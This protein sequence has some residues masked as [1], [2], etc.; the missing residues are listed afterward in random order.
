M[1]YINKKPFLSW[2]EE[3]GKSNTAASVSLAAM[4]I[5]KLE[6]KREAKGFKEP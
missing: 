5:R 6:K 1:F 3:G 4:L 2:G